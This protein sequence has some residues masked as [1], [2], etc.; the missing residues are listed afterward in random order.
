MPHFADTLSRLG[1]CGGARS[2][3]VAF[4]IL[5]IKN[6]FISESTRTISLPIKH[7][8]TGVYHHWLRMINMLCSMTYAVTTAVNDTRQSQISSPLNSRYYLLLLIVGSY[9]LQSTML[10]AS[11]SRKW[12]GGSLPVFSANPLKPSQDYMGCCLVLVGLFQRRLI[13]LES[14]LRLDS[15][16]HSCLGCVLRV[17]ELV[18]G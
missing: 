16:C 3:A 10:Q 5:L 15:L 2:Q 14:G 1:G 18:K 13:G 7:S 9:S 12:W 17:F 11:Y 8:T 6:H 4:D